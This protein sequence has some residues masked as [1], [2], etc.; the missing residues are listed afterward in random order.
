MPF[1]AA[2]RAHRPALV[3]LLAVA[4]ITLGFPLLRSVSSTG[5]AIR[6]YRVDGTAAHVARFDC[7]DARIRAAVP[8]KVPVY[9][10]TNF[11][12]RQF[13]VPRLLEHNDYATAPV[14]PAWIVS[15]IPTADGPCPD[16]IEAHPA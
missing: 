14:A 1:V 12:A 7:I 6:P 2:E 15:I 11:L 9:L 13:M 10:D 3:G 16:T 8:P 5:R 4:A